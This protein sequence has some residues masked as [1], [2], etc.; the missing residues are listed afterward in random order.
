VTNT[1]VVVFG[2]VVD[3]RLDGPASARWLRELAAELDDV[4][5]SMRRAPFGFTQGDELQGLLDTAADPLTAVLRATLRAEAPPAMRWAIA[6]GDVEP[7]EGP[8]TQRTGPAFVAAR[9]LIDAARRRRDRLVVRS[10]DPEADELLDDI[11][12]VL[13]TLLVELT[14][15]QREVAR[16][17]LVDGLRQADAAARLD[18]AR[19][20]VSVAAER[21]HV[22]DIDRL[23]RATLAL[24]RAGI[25]RRSGAET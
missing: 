7:G 1:A 24:L 6:A 3:S 11:A 23:R 21:A 15:R 4:Y 13:G 10:G 12:P 25:A 19:P 8:T 2:D 22:R 14:D 5:G 20:T 17:L 16:L 18:V 9:E